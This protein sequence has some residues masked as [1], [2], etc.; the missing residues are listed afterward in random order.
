MHLS[1]CMCL[2]IYRIFWLLYSFYFSFVLYIVIVVLVAML[3]LHVAPTSSINDCI[4]WI[5]IHT[6]RNEIDNSTAPSKLN[7]LLNLVHCTKYVVCTKPTLHTEYKVGTGVD[8]FNLSNY[9]L[10]T[11][12]LYLVTPFNGQNYFDSK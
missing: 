4:N 7:H 9:H 3:I 2:C 8:I 1:M 12:Y 10:Y 5:L 11:L 6:E